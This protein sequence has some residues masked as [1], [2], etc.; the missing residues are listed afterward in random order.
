[1]LRFLKKILAHYI[2]NLLFLMSLP[3]LFVSLGAYIYHYSPEDK[4]SM[5]S[6]ISSSTHQVLHIKLQENLVDRKTYEDLNLEKD[7]IYLSD[8]EETLAHAAQNPLIKGVL[9]ELDNFSADLVTIDALVHLLQ[10]FKTSQKPIVCHSTNCGQM[11]LYIAAQADH[12]VLY[13]HAEV[14]LLGFAHMRYFYKNALDRLGVQFSLFRSGPSKD[15][16]ETLTQTHMSPEAKKNRL[17]FLQQ[18]DEKYFK[19]ITEGRHINPTQLEE[20]RKSTPNAKTSVLPYFSAPEAVQ[21]ELADEVG[22]LGQAKAFFMKKSP[23]QT[24]EGE[25]I[26][27]NDTPEAQTFSIPPP[28]QATKEPLFIPCAAYKKYCCPKAVQQQGEYKA[29]I[30]RIQGEIREGKS[31]PGVIGAEDTIKKIY[32]WAEIYPTLFL[33]IDSPG[34]SA[35]ASDK[36]RIALEEIK[37]RGTYV[38]IIMRNQCTS[39]ALLIACAAHEIW[40]FDAS[41]VGSVGVFML[42]PH[43]KKLLTKLK[44]KVDGVQTHPSA[45]LNHA[46]HRNF[47]PK[48]KALFQKF[49]DHHF[50]H[51]LTVA[52]RNGKL[53]RTEVMDFAGGKVFLGQAALD[54]GIADKVIDDLEQAIQA[55]MKERYPHATY[56]LEYEHKKL[57]LHSLLFSLRL[58]FIKALLG[59]RLY[60]QYSAILEATEQKREVQARCYV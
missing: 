5:R 9:L 49:V 16:L 19:G 40:C 13:P 31:R 15:A 17:L 38:V 27:N 45:G 46:H 41:I 37:A 35:T 34:G 51:F 47:T 3:F 58:L 39:G 56:T 48:E 50:E 43:W 32:E 55:K 14:S 44:I 8:I 21:Y 1:M 54:Y 10:E 22:Y 23:A 12:H 28:Q 4:S 59:T 60:E 24:T 53:S 36:I 52:E 29:G 42:F 33:E 26:K 2:G 57:H 30:C 7:T 18:L 6:L 20:L 11:A 25:E